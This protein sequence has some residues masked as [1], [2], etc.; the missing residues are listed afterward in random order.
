LR[1]APQKQQLLPKRKRKKLRLPLALLRKT[2]LLALPM[3]PL[4]L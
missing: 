4:E 2:L 3:R 1:L